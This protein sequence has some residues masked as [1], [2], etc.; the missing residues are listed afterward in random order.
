MGVR[1]TSRFESEPIFEV[2]KSS[3]TTFPEKTFLRRNSRIFALPR[4]Q[5]S[6]RRA[7]R[8]AF[9]R[10]RMMVSSVPYKL[11]EMFFFISLSEPHMLH[12]TKS[13]RP[14]AS[15]DRMRHPRIFGCRHQGNEVRPGYVLPVTVVN[16]PSRIAHAEITYS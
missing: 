16:F 8:G 3:D 5:I 4:T 6:S 14:L 10:L 12:E 15:H 7:P 11:S 1:C 2:C 9:V 13:L